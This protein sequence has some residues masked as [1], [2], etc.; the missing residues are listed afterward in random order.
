MDRSN[1]ELRYFR[2]QT[3]KE[4]E[5]RLRTT[6]CFQLLY[7][8]KKVN[9]RERNAF[10]LWHNTTLR[11]KIKG[12][13]TA[14][15]GCW[16]VVRIFNNIS[17]RYEDVFRLRSFEESES[18]TA[19]VVFS[20]I[21][22]CFDVTHLKK[23]FS[24][25]SDT[26]SL[27]T[28]KDKGINNRLTAYFKQE[29]GHGIH[30]LECQFHINELLFNHVV[31]SVEGKPAAPDRMGQD[32]VY[33]MIKLFKPGRLTDVVNCSDLSTTLRAVQCLKSALTWY[34]EIEG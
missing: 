29:V 33:N 3:I 26:T 14:N 28:G 30:I 25:M 16:I 13:V 11:T 7:D 23:V 18:V 17:F 12:T 22:N 8:G 21:I 31:K 4:I 32:S 5:N 19:D 20:A 2:A 6:S 34:A 1:T 27:N 24:V 10:F 15:K 9:R